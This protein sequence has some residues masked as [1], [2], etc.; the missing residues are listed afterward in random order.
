MC[1]SNDGIDFCIHL[2]K[3]SESMSHS[4]AAPALLPPHTP[5][6]PFR[7]VVNLLW[8]NVILPSGPVGPDFILA[9]THSKEKGTLLS[10]SNC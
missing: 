2:A 3:G 4:I 5:G 10:F 9:D 7:W 1:I 8:A 6:S